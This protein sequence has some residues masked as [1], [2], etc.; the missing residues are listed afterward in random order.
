VISA[1]SEIKPIAPLP[2]VY[3]LPTKFEVAAK[4]LAGDSKAPIL[5][6]VP[7]TECFYQW[8]ETDA[9]FLTYAIEYQGKI[10]PGPR[11]SKTLISKIR[12][13]GADCIVTM[14]VIDIDN[15]DHKSWGPTKEIRD[16][17]R[18]NFLNKLQEVAA[19]FPLAWEWTLLYFTRNGVRLVYVLDK[20]LTLEDSE[21]KHQ[22]LCQQFVQRGIGADLNVSDWTRCY[23]LPNVIRE[24][25]KTWESDYNEILLQ[26]AN[27]IDAIH[28]PSA[29]KL[30]KT[31]EYGEI[32][33]YDTDMPD[34]DEAKALCWFKDQNSSA[35]LQTDWYK[36]AKKQLR[37]RECFDCLFSH[38][39]IA[40]SGQRNSTLHKYVGQ[41]ISL[42]FYIPGT[43]PQHIF[44][45][46]IEPVEQLSPDNDTADWFVVL[47][48][49]ILRLW[50]K[51]EA[52]NQAVNAVEIAKVEE[53]QD[54]FGRIMSGMDKWV[55]D[56]RFKGGTDHER[57]AYAMRRLIVSCG[58]GFY[59]MGDNGHYDPIQLNKDQLIPYILIKG[60]D[61]VLEIR[62]MTDGGETYVSVAE[63]LNNYSTQVKEI[64]A[65]AQI[66]GAFI[67]D[68]D[69][70]N[71]TLVIP[72]YRRN[73]NIVPEY[74]ADVDQWLKL[75]FEDNYE[76]GCKWLSWALAWD[77]GTIC[78]LSLE[79]RAGSGKK[80]LVEGLKECL[81][82]PA[83]AG[84]EDLVGD[85]Q[86]GLLN[87]PF[88]VVNEGWPT[89]SA[90]KHPAD[91]FRQL[92]SADPIRCNTKFG[93]PV[94]ARNPVRI[95]FTA[96]NLDVVKQLSGNRDLSPEDREAL[97]IRLL[98]FRI[99]NGAS[100]WLRMQG[101]TK[102]TAKPGQR[103]IGGDAGE[104]SDFVIAKHFMWL[105][106]NRKGPVGS[107]LLVEGNNDQDVM[108]DMRTQSGSSPIV[109]EAMIHLIDK[110]RTMNGDEGVAVVDGELYM[111]TADVLSYHRNEL[112]DM[113]RDKLDLQKIGKVFKSVAVEVPI[114]GFIL[115]G[116][117]SAGPK[118]WYKIDCELLL[119]VAERDGWKS[120]TLAKL[121]KEQKERANGT[122]L[123]TAVSSENLERAKTSPRI[124]DFGLA[125]RGL[126]SAT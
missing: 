114:K 108:F 24:K 21:Q 54:Q 103:W 109:I 89:K 6:L 102:L 18:G 40:E 110:K 65:V 124:I 105:Y 44:G 29:P 81:E 68:M 67:Q 34:R 28:M 55:T 115:K 16:Y 90:S 41:A 125:T 69:T 82:L 30:T 112:A 13:H 77:E 106:A 50:A 98:H 87:S 78:A 20:Y 118:R 49:H 91:S 12:Q 48:D 73:P 99:G 43:E 58:K 101:G 63:L 119:R 74:N 59:I 70:P 45:L 8:H 79:G 122:Y 72:S 111:C 46:F 36:K 23:R 1:L 64:K 22:W 66:D 10:E 42:L 57:L 62:K 38:K 4:Q 11:C 15:P 5:E 94:M 92:V 33:V 83:A 126:S 100:D 76:L 53:G 47:W 86:Y 32:K 75:L 9:H 61:S 88:L 2:H 25:E 31:N 95:V 52:K 85:Y 104:Q 96:N 56:P 71:A 26:E 3:L 60:M 37:G 123:P 39:P 97:S 113:S 14:M 120:T 121:V 117:E 27:R 93:Q 107:R 51:E 116:K 19:T 80:M 17:A 35:L 84:A 7:F